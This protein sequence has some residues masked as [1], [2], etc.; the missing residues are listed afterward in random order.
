MNWLLLS[1][2]LT[3]EPSA[4]R[5]HIWR[6]LKRIGAISILDAV[7]A[8]PDSPRTHEQFQWLAAE[9]QE[10]GGEA[11]FWRAQSELTGQTEALVTLFS[12]QIDAVY[13]G[14]LNR[15]E[16]PEADLSALAQEYQQVQQRDYFQSRIG[17]Q[18]RARLLSARGEEP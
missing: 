2:K 14:L 6:K 7:W 13:Q 1:Y 9:I 3:A 18:V 8:L 4:R 10:M 17:Q 11:M 5:V 16:Q 15:L 12:K